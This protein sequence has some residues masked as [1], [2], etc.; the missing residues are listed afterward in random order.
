MS[1]MPDQI[2]PASFRDPSGFIFTDGDTLYRQVNQR[3]QPDYDALIK[4]GLVSTLTEAG[5]L[6]GFEETDH[7]G[8]TE[9]AY[10]VIRPQCVPFLSYPYEWCFS[11]L[12]DAALATLRIEKLALQQGMSLKDAS[13]YNIQFVRGEPTL[14]DT[15]SFERYSPGQ[16][17]VA[18]RQFCQHFLAPLALMALVDTRLDQLLRIH[19]DGLPLDLASSL[20]PWKTRLNPGLAMHIH[21]HAASMKRY[22]GRDVKQEGKRLK[23]GLNARLGLIDSLESA[24]HR[25]RW[26]PAGSSWGDYSTAHYADA[27]FEMKR[28]QVQAWLE[29]IKPGSVWDLGANVGTFSRIAADHAG[30]VLS[31]DSDRD[32]VEKNYRQSRKEA[33]EN[34]YPL[35]MDL[36]NPSP[37]QGWDFRERM[38]LA[39]RGPADAVLALALIHHLAISNNVPLERLA[40]FFSRL[41]RWLIL[42]FVPKDDPQTQILLRTRQDIFEEYDSA[43]MQAAFATSFDLIESAQLEGS[44]RSL[45]LFE[46]I[47]TR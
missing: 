40:Q 43:H 5:L 45:H 41:G 7:K 32:A 23:M 47:E 6:L 46:R 28:S 29:R 19:I 11:Q 25:L 4:S 36:T 2:N 24:I 1:K 34:V 12:K 15:L 31:L 33:R 30:F 8:L 37:D 17:W 22:A 20:L 38:S 26:E 18:Y 3:Y 35:L 21:T 39:S 9:D 16:P 27:A 10:K 44:N 13:A 14:I 42:E